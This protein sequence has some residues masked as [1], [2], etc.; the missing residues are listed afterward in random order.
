LKDVG[1]G[2]LTLGQAS[3][4][5]SGGE[6]QRVKLATELAKRDT[7]KTLY[8]LDEP[9]TGL[10]F[11]DIKVLMSVLNKLVDKGNTV[12][13][14]EHNMDVIKMADWIIDMG[15]EGGDRGGRIVCQGTPEEVALCNESY[16]ARYLKE[17]LS[18]ANGQ[19]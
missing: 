14:I 2:Y 12:L 9:T 16:T 18:A 7:G 3:T 13:I 6:A 15:P 8:V 10:H 1:L 17:E 4:T 19:R 5:I 11:E